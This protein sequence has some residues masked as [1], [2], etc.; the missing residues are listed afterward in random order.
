M[1]PTFSPPPRR[2]VSLVPSLTESLFDLGLGAAVV[3]ITDYCTHPAQELKGLPRLGGPKNPR[4]D[5]LLS[6]KPDLVLAN[7]EENTRHS[8][9]AIQTAGVPVWVSFPQTVRQSMD[10]L[11]ALA[12]LFRSPAASARLQTL[13]RSVL[14]AAESARDGPRLRYFCPVWY[15]QTQ[16]GRPWWRAF[17]RNT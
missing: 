8:I 10:L 7:R 12:D 4:L 6:L 14:W 17:N 11:W 13:E 15:D 16:D 3:G 2:V 5:E 1:I 9:E